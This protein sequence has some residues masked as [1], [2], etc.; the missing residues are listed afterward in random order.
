ME[1]R[2]A[3]MI[4]KGRGVA[5]E[6]ALVLHEQVVHSYISCREKVKLSTEMQNS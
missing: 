3:Y 4:A 6:P 5:S 1:V 2:R